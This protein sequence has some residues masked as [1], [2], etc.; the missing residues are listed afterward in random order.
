[1]QNSPANLS[2]Y[3]QAYIACKKSNDIIIEAYIYNYSNGHRNF[4][5]PTK[6]I[7]ACVWPSGF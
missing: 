7:S 1:M 3:L 4:T 2:L 5:F 6:F